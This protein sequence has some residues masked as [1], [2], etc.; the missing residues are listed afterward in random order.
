M[1]ATQYDATKDDL[2][3]DGALTID[4]IKKEFGIGRTAVYELMNAGKLP[5]SAAT[6]RRLVPRRAL[7]QLLAN[8]L[9]G[10]TGQ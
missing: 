8:E 9:V 1:N 7:K 4:G 6:G 10:A 2:F 3:A 5:Y